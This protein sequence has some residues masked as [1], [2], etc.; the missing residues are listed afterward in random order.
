ML[1]SS[2]DRRFYALALKLESSERRYRR[3]FERSLAGVYFSTLE[4]RILDCNDACSR[5]LGYTSRQEQLAHSERDIYLGSVDGEAFLSKL[6][7]QRALTNFEHRLQRRDNSTR[8][9]LENATLL[10][11]KDGATSVAEGT[12][13]DITERK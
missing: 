6:K 10:E 12:L 2:V 3:L 7:E 11:R 4:G 8:W 1:T 9:V 13:I 5:I